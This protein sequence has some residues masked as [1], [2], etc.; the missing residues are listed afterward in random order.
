MLSTSLSFEGV[1]DVCKKYNASIFESYL[2]KQGLRFILT[3]FHCG[4]R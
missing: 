3:L 2:T 4:V 1:K